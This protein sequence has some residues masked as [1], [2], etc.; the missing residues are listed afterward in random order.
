MGVEN[1]EMI[2][3]TS[4]QTFFVSQICKL[5]SPAQEGGPSISER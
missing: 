1:P 5:E 4:V 2:R 3:K